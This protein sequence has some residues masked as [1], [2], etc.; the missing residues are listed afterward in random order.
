MVAL[1]RGGEPQFQAFSASGRPRVAPVSTDLRIGRLRGVQVTTVQS[2]VAS[3]GS[4]AKRGVTKTNTGGVVVSFHRASAARGGG[5]DCT[6]DTDS[7][8]GTVDGEVK[9]T[10]ELFVAGGLSIGEREILLTQVILNNTRGIANIALQVADN[11]GLL[12]CRS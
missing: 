6:V 11:D 7:F 8:V 9:S 4:G 1:E 5:R 2:V 10:T 3:T 12:D